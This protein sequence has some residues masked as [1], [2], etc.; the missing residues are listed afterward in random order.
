MPV[1]PLLGLDS[2]PELKVVCNVS[3]ISTISWITTLSS[4]YY[5]TLRLTAWCLRYIANLKLKRQ[6]LPLNLNQHLVVSEIESAE[7]FMFKEAQSASYLKEIEHLTQ[8]RAIPSHSPLISLNPF[9]DK[10]WVVDFPI[11]IFINHLFIPSSFLGR[12]YCVIDLSLS[13]GPLRPEL[14][15]I[16]CRS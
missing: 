12:V 11:Q 9:I 8:N 5:R 15:F 3:Q 13:L 16:C 4:D 1:Q 14:A 6:R 2:T 10:G 7:P